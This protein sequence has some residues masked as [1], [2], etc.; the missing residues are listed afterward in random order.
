MITQIN[1]HHHHQ[2]RIMGMILRIVPLQKRSVQRNY[3][4]LIQDAQT[5]DEASKCVSDMAPNQ[6]K[7]TAF[8]NTKVVQKVT[9]AE[10]IA[11]SM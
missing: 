5:K 6:A 3:H 10:G 9:E 2:Q 1:Y 8:V 4:A 7:Q 11:L